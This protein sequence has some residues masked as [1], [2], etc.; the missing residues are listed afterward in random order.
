MLLTSAFAR[1]YFVVVFGVHSVP[2]HGVF[3][4]GFLTE[5]FLEVIFRKKK[6]DSVSRRRPRKHHKKGRFRFEDQDETMTETFCWLD[7]RPCRIQW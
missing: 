4:G 2:F 3:C 5:Q 1:V 7:Q 6:T